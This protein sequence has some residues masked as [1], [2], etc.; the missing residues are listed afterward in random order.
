MVNE[1]KCPTNGDHR[2]C[3]EAYDVM[4]NMFSD[5]DKFRKEVFLGGVVKFLHVGVNDVGK[6]IIVN[7]VVLLIGIVKIILKGI[8]KI[9]E[10]GM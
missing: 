8:V 3:D 4:A 10:V 2:E 7:Y 9:K 1:R 6:I 5:Q